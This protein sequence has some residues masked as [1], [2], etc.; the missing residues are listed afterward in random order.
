MG[1]LNRDIVWRTRRDVPYLRFIGARW[2]PEGC[3]FPRP[4]GWRYGLAWRCWMTG[5]S[6][7]API[8]LNWALFYW[9]E[10]L[11]RL[12]HPPIDEDNPGHDKLAAIASFGEIRR[13]DA[14]VKQKDGEIFLLRAALNRFSVELATS[15][16]QPIDVDCL[17]LADAAESVG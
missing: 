15:L 10:L 3:L 9:R 7:C 17:P 1:N 11:G 8:P 5:G 6:I 2:C 4:F 16:P 14:L 13:L 12:S